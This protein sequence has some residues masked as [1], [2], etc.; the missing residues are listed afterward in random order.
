MGLGGSLHS[1][2]LLTI[3]SPTYNSGK[4][5]NNETDTFWNSDEPKTGSKYKCVALNYKTGRWVN[6]KCKPE[7]SRRF[8]CEKG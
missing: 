1:Q 5:L 4:P 7:K 2:D 3:F 6:R 8:I